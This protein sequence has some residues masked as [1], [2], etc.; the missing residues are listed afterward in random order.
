MIGGMWAVALTDSYQMAIIMI[1]LVLLLAVVL[2]D[3]GGWSAIAVQLPENTFRLIPLQHDW[4]HWLNY[5]RMW[6]IFGLAD[7]ASQNLAGRAMAARSERV[8]QNAFYL[9]SFGYLC[10]A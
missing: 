10:S 9:G 6:V 1:G 4:E 7:L 5:F 2:F 3:L 8:A